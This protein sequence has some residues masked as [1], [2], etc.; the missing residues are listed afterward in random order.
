MSAL[1]LKSQRK[2]FDIRLRLVQKNIR[3]TEADLKPTD[4]FLTERFITASVSIEGSLNENDGF[5]DITPSD[6][7]ATEYRPQLNAVSVDIETDY[8]ASTLYSI[9]IYS[10]DVSICYMVGS[11]EDY[12]EQNNYGGNLEL[13]QLN[14]EREVINAFVKKILDL[15][16]DVIMGWNIVNFDL[17]CLQ[18]FCDRLKMPLL[19]GRNN[20]AISWRKERYSND[21]YYALLPG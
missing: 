16:P 18:N 8:H 7:R 21:R 19:L 12:I 15:D 1:Y 17:R 9:G 2:L 4:R 13:C 20:E 11:T 3:I 5:S 6:L 10:D 14:S